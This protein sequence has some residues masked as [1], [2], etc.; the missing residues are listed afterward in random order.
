MIKHSIIIICYNQA[1][2][3][4]DSINSCINQSLPPHEII[5]SDDCSSDNTWNIINEYDH[6]LFN[7]KAFRNSHN[8]GLHENI[9]IAHS[10]ITGNVVSHCAGDDLLEKDTLYEISKAIIKNNIRIELDKFIVTLNSYLLYPD[11]KKTLWNNYQI[12]DKDPLKSR[13]RYGFS[14]RGVGL[15][16]SLINEVPEQSE[17]IKKYPDFSF[18]VDWIKGFEEILISDK[19]IFVDYAGPI[20][21]I[22]TG[23]TSKNSIKEQEKSKLLLIRFIEKKYGQYWNEQDLIYIRFLEVS[24]KYRLNKNPLYFLITLYYWFRNYNNFDPNYPWIREGKFMIPERY[25]TF[26]KFRIYPLLK[27]LR[28]GCFKT[29]V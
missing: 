7:I 29:V 27:T 16:K 23:V 2:F 24:L 17:L 14:H 10:Y 22:G 1:E 28:N 4:K 3:I 20:Y 11:G 8:V 13:L 18:G 6:N 26:F 21:R 25:W 9:R 19:I 12:R 15:S 5:I